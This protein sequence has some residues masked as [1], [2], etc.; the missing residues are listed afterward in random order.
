ML[1]NINLTANNNELIAIIG[2]VGCGKSTL[3][4]Y[5]LKENFSDNGKLSYNGVFAY[6]EQEPF[7][8]SGTVKE[9]ILFGN[10]YK[11]D[12]YSNIIKYCCLNEDF[13]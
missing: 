2:S 9:N 6:V 7:I 1:N 5:I 12:K 10:V 13:L 3:L 11:N 8:I 4:N